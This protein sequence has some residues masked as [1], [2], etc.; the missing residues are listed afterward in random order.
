MRERSRSQLSTVAPAIVVSAWTFN[1]VALGWRRRR[2]AT[3]PELENPSPR[4]TLRQ[5]RLQD[6]DGGIARPRVVVSETPPQPRRGPASPDAGKGNE[7]NMEA[8]Y[9][10]QIEDM[11]AARQRGGSTDSGL[12]LTTEKISGLPLTK[13]RVSGLPLANIGNKTDPAVRP[14]TA[15]GSKN[16]SLEITGFRASTGQGGI[17]RRIHD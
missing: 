12:P 2:K 7:L 11:T 5:A 17:H 9:E 16:G 15:A 3:A 14:H 1:A 6:F 13:E 10:T 4:L 8:P